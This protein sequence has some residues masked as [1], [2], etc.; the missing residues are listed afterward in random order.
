MKYFLLSI[1][2]FTAL[3]SH[4]VTKSPIRNTRYLV[5]VKLVDHE[6]S[7]CEILDNSGP[8]LIVKIDPN[9][10]PL[11]HEIK[12]KGDHNF[13]E[14]FLVIRG[15]LATSSFASFQKSKNVFIQV[16]TNYLEN[17]L[18]VQNFQF[19]MPSSGIAS[20]SNGGIIPFQLELNGT[21]DSNQIFLPEL[22]SE[23]NN[24]DTTPTYTEIKFKSRI[25][26]QCN[27]ENSKVSKCVR[28]IIDLEIKKRVRK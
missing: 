19:F 18:M 2:V 21:G 20:A 22:R 9:C 5:D 11:T 28:K 25:E 7:E 3:E 14:E 13:S 12:V 10:V 24:G 6:N 17:G 16:D 26:G 8:N 4:G 23:E 15:S 1:L 27:T